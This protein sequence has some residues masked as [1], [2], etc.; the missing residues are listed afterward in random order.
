VSLYLI[1]LNNKNCIFSFVSCGISSATIN[2]SQGMYL[3]NMYDSTYLGVK[4][5]Y[6]WNE[7]IRFVDYIR[8]MEKSAHVKT[9]IKESVA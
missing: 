6:V 2:R 8:P 3:I 1:V 9:P 7:G 4:F 5:C